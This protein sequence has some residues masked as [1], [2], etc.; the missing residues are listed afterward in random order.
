MIVFFNEIQ[1]NYFY[2]LV[3]FSKIRNHFYKKKKITTNK[4]FTS[5][6]T[7]ALP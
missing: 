6:M 7:C 5:Y 2:F 3:K 1:E 4:E